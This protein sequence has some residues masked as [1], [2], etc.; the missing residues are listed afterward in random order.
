MINEKEKLNRIY[1]E[2]A[3]QIL[4][5]SSEEL[6]DSFTEM[7]E[8]PDAVVSKNQTALA[9]AIAK[10]RRRRLEAARAALNEENADRGRKIL[11]IPTGDRR[12]RLS[13]ILSNPNI[14]QTL[15]ARSATGD[16]MS[17]EEVDSLLSDLLELGIVGDSK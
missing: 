11:Q 5:T 4:E 7:G 14:P 3:H 15:A 17:D 2:L 1:E 9:S 10:S 6:R 8:D 12:K 16:A 13:A